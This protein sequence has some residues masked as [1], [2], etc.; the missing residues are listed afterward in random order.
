MFKKYN[1]I[2]LLV[3]INLI[4]YTNCLS[5]DYTDSIINNIR[6]APCYGSKNYRYIFR[7]NSL[8]THPDKGGNLNN[9]IRIVQAK[10]IKDNKCIK[11]KKRST[12]TKKQKKEKGIKNKF[13]KI[14]NNYYPIVKT[15]SK[16]FIKDIY[17]FGGDFVKS[18]NEGFKK[19]YKEAEEEAAKKESSFSDYIPF[20]IPFS[21]FCFFGKKKRHLFMI[22][23]HLHLLSFIYYSILHKN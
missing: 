6:N 8:K 4:Q 15:I 14:F 21:F 22:I 10:N 12:Q 17:E 7:I 2:L 16:N 19:G 1:I 9:Y 3:S 20:F 23:F 5:K 18:F 11:F 13:N